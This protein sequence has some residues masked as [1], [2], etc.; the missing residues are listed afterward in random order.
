MRKYPNPNTNPEHATPPAGNGNREPFPPTPA[1]LE[2]HPFVRILQYAG[3][4]EKDFDPADRVPVPL[5]QAEI[6][7]LAQHHLDAVYQFLAF[8]KTGGSFGMSDVHRD[9]YRRERFVALADLLSEEDQKRFGEIMRIR[10]EYVE[11]LSDPEEEEYDEH[12]E[13]EIYEGDESDEN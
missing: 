12:D 3:F 11:T 5:T 13:H 1:V 4:Y 6:R 8:Q 7:T 9:R 10:D 2:D